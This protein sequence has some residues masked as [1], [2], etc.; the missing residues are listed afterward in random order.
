LGR[1]IAAAA[2]VCA[3]SLPS[4]AAERAVR[5]GELAAALAR[6]AP[7]DT[8]R[9]EPGVHPGPVVVG[10]RVRL[11]GSPGAIL[12][13]GGDGVPL[14]LAADGAEVS[15]VTVRNGGADLSRD[16]AAV[17]L[18]EAHGVTIAHC[19][20]EARAFGIYLRGGGGHHVVANEVVGDAR[21]ARSRRGNGIHL[22]HTERNEIRDNRIADVRDA[23]YFSFAHDNAIRGNQATGVRY[24][25]HYMYSERNTLEENRL[26]RCIGGIALMFSR[27]NRIAANVSSDNRDFGMLC[28]QIEHSE[29]RDNEVARNGR[30]FFVEHSVGNRFVGNRMEANGV[31]LFLTAGSEDN[32]LTGNRFEGNLVQAYQGSRMPNEWSEAGRGNEWSDYT[33]FDWN[34]DGIGEVPYRLQTAV[35]ALLARRPVTRWFLMSPALGLL[36]WWDAQTGVEPGA[37]DRAP[38]VVSR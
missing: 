28:L 16:D 1:L 15:G 19:R 31:G 25:I 30:G 4:L 21:L 12:D 35:S 10:V 13:G 18:R 29:I 8:L 33:G 17:L 38:L 24:G 9:L 7:G 3:A 36:D 26:R 34:G 2:I 27:R 11:V 32:V 23:M 20:V 14:T 6:A 5:P 22:W 37:L